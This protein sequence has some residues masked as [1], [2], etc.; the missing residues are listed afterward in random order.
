MPGK[1][2]TEK[3]SLDM[4]TTRQTNGKTDGQTN[5]HVL[6]RRHDTRSLKKGRSNVFISVSEA[7]T[8]SWFQ[9]KKKEQVKRKKMNKSG[10]K[11]MN[12]WKSVTPPNTF[13]KTIK[14]NKSRS[15]R[16]D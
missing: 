14:G 8:I 7:I 9:R 3:E 13:S 16:G 5:I 15:L 1:I 6:L 10:E 4:E 11:K 12:K 2:L